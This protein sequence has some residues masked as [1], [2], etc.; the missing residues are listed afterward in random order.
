MQAE[1]VRAGVEHMRRNR[2]NFRSMGAIYWQLNDCWP[3]ASWSGIDYYGRLK[4]LH[5]SSVRFFKDVL[6]SAVYDDKNTVLISLTNDLTEN[7]HKKVYYAI[8][9]QDGDVIKYEEKEITADAL[10]SADVFTLNTSGADIYN[11][12]IEYGMDG[13]M[14]GAVLLCPNKH[15][16]YKNPNIKYSIGR[17][18]NKTVIK[19]S[20]DSL[21]GFTELKAKNNTVEFSDNYFFLSPNE[22]REITCDE[23]IEDLSVRSV[24]D[25]Y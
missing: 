18:E 7:I 24:Y 8:K 6:L 10:S 19:L 20:C 22:E 5:Y 4:A 11:Q 23:Y 17:S 14:S 3:V 15:F 16:N 1:A 9:T 25:T 2:N 13:N 12:Y 21:A